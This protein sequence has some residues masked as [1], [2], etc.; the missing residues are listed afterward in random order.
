MIRGLP[1]SGASAICLTFA[2]LLGCTYT[3]GERNVVTGWIT[4]DYFL[5]QEIVPLRNGDEVGGWRVACVRATMRDGESTAKIVCEI[6]VGIPIR[7]EAEGWIS[8]N[9]AREL[10][11]LTANQ[12][13]YE[14]L[15]ERGAGSML[16]LACERF[17]QGFSSLFEMR[18]PGSR[19]RRQCDPRL[20]PV[21]F[22]VL[23]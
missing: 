14:V 21:T 17:K 16:G 11:A 4:P 13:A 20:K 19:V 23:Q 22:D 8:V 12:I 5:F 18:L 7:T 3:R 15:S 2:I 1:T 9:L 6:E 10:A